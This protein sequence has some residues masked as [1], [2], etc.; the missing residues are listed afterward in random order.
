MAD[1]VTTCKEKLAARQQL[2]ARDALALLDFQVERKGPE[3]VYA[4]TELGTCVNFTGGDVE[5]R[6]PDCIVG[7]VFADLGLL[8]RLT[9]TS[10][11][12]TANTEADEPFEPAAT[13]YLTTAQIAQDRGD[14]WGAAVDA[15]HRAYARNHPLYP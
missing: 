5:E 6:V 1:I 9:R 15:A 14:T 4:R 3:H 2:D 8:D 12:E 10:G 7:H 13:E 11:A